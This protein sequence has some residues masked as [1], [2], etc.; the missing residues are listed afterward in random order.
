M[1]EKKPPCGGYRMSMN[2]LG[3]THTAHLSGDS[4]KGMTWITLQRV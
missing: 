3:K 2:G 4:K 1:K